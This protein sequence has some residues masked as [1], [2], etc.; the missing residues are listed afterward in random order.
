[1]IVGL[2]A[3]PGMPAP[4]LAGAIRAALSAAGLHP[5]R[6]TA[7]ATLDRRAAE[8]GI[9]SVAAGLGWALVSFPAAE[10]GAQ[11]VPNRSETVVAA[12]G[13]PSVAEAAALAAAGPGAVLILPKRVFPGITV[14]VA[15]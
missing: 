14:A 15:G 10:L 2:G 3:R 11:D 1:V 5:A 4:A 6:V 7:L 9:R 13:T 8:E 12:V